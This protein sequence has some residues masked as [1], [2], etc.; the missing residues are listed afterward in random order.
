[1]IEVK[2]AGI[3][4]SLMS[5]HRVV[6]LKELDADRYLPIWIGPYEAEALSIE[7]QQI[8]LARPL[9]HDLLKNVIEAM[10]G[11]VQ[12]IVVSELKD[13]TFYARIVIS[14]DGRIIEVDARPSDAMNLAV[15]AGAPIYVAEEVM[16]AAGITPDRDLME[17]GREEEEEERSAFD[18]FLRGLNIDDL[19]IH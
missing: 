19:P 6:L 14:M 17:E 7:L 11:T 9:T 15:R 8:G 4:V 18:E 5:Q 3:Q 12:Y 10:G 16:E 2:I 1:M 13:D